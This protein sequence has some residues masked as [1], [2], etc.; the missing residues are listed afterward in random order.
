MNEEGVEDVLG[1]GN[2]VLSELK[3]AEEGVGRSADQVG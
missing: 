1:F 2:G 3:E